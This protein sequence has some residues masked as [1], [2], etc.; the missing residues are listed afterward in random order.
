MI[1]D[2]ASDDEF[3][4]ASDFYARKFGGQRTGACTA[5]L[6][7]GSTITVD[8]AWR[9]NPEAG[10]AGLLRRQGHKVYHTENTL[11]HCLFGLLFWDELF[12]TG[13]LHSGFD[14]CLKSLKNKTFMRAFGPKI[15]SKLTS[16]VRTGRRS[17]LSCAASP[18]AGRSPMGYS[19]WDVM[20]TWMRCARFCMR[21]AQA[22]RYAMLR[23]IDGRTTRR[24]AMAFL[25]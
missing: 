13:Q 20:W 12:E 6:R 7:A 10:V 9:G 1:D 23:L 3:M 11:W 4:F 25:I 8:D 15:Q 16:T 17:R 2:P 21:A 24:C 14:G 18:P 5:L 19:A 22:Q